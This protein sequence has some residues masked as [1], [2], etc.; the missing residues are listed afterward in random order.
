MSKSNSLNVFPI[1]ITIGGKNKI[2]EGELVRTNAPRTVEKILAK[3]PI[4]GTA[5]K[6]DNQINLPIG[7]EM[8]KEKSKKTAKKGDIGYWPMG[9]SLSFFLDDAQ[10]YG[11]VNIIGRITSNMDALKELRLISTLKIT[12]K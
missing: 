8:G 11:E 7:I 4:T 12:A 6:R 9:D 5:S 1:I 3:L 2:V 10:P